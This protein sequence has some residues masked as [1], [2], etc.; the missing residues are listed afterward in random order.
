M[1]KPK[2]V[3]ADVSDSIFKEFGIVIPVA[4]QKYPSVEWLHACLSEINL[5]R[6]FK[7][8]ISSF[9]VVSSFHWLKDHCFIIICIRIWTKYF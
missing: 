9:N 7:D 4:S 5:F 1:K 2:K 6:T 8:F 3:T